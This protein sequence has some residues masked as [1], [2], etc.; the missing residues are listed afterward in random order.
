M[1]RLAIVLGLV[2]LA[3]G[4]VAWVVPYLTRERDY[5]AVTPQ[6]DPLLH[7]TTLALAPGRSACMD[8]AV[9]DPLSQEARFRVGTFRGPAVPLELTISGGSYQAHAEIPGDYGDSEV[10][11]VPLPPP[12]EPVATTIC[13]RNAGTRRVGVYAS[14]DRTNGRSRTFV[15]GEEVPADLAIRFFEREPVSVLERLPESLERASAFRPVVTPGVLYV[16]LA[17]FLVG[18]PLG[19][20]WAFASAAGAPVPSS[21]RGSPPPGRPSERA[22]AAP[23]PARGS[24]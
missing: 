15:N 16:L 20:L 10:I 14:D 21:G 2:L 12:A 19:V 22:P 5:T 23:S 1:R 11:A 6:P 24:R 8:R 4:A 3:A 7:V 9:L 18:T 13:I 17:L